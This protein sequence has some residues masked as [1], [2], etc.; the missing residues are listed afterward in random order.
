MQRRTIPA[1]GISETRSIATSA[2]N[3]RSEART[4]RGGIYRWEFSVDE[5]IVHHEI[6][7]S[8]T[9]TDTL[10]SLDATL[11]G[12]GLAYTFDKLARPISRPSG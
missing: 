7:G 8:L 1:A 10:F 9:I 11:E 5:R 3:R 4:S 6:G 12:V 2:R